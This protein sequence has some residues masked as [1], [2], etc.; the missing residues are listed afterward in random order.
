[1]QPEILRHVDGTG[2]DRSGRADVIVIAVSHR[3]RLT[4]AQVP[5]AEKSNEIPALPPLLRQLPARRGTLV[6]ADALLQALHD[7]EED[8][9]SAAAHALGEVKPEIA[10]LVPEK[11]EERRSR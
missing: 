9:Q 2:I 10:T 8:V 4:L 5:I 7:H 1:M 3:L 6:T 11:R